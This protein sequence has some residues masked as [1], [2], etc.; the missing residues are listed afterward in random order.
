MRACH[1]LVP[2]W[3]SVSYIYVNTHIYIYILVKSSGNTV[4]NILY[5]LYMN[6]TCILYE[7]NTQ[8]T[9]SILNFVLGLKFDF[10]KRLMGGG[11]GSA[12]D[13]PS[14]TLQHTSEYVSIRQNTS[15][16]VEA[17]EK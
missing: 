8:G 17:Q 5:V 7:Q 1:T 6:K 12:R 10:Q 3:E 15:E 9:Q 13:T 14:S 2:N 11:G 4:I 16:E